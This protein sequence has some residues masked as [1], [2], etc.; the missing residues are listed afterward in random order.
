MFDP[1]WEREIPRAEHDPKQVHRKLTELGAPG[2]CVLVTDEL[3]LETSALD[4]ALEEVFWD[5][6]DVILVCLPGKLAY[7]QDHNHH[8]GLLSRP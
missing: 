6:Y 4:R 2:T 7:Y 8:R 3:L 1:R 5:W